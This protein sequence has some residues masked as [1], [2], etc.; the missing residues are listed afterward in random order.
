M[1]GFLSNAS[2]STSL[3]SRTGDGSGSPFALS[4][5]R[6]ALDASAPCATAGRA[7]EIAR[8]KTPIL[9]IDQSRHVKKEDVTQAE[10]ARTT[11][12]LRGGIRSERYRGKTARDGD[13]LVDTGLRLSLSLAKVFR[14]AQPAQ[15]A[16]RRPPYKLEPVTLLLVF[17]FPMKEHSKAV[18]ELLQW[19]LQLPAAPHHDHSRDGMTAL[20][21]PRRQTP[22]KGRSPVSKPE[23]MQRIWHIEPS[24]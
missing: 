2:R 1:A 3:S 5:C 22:L 12:T 6:A 23:P 14:G 24:P 7:S 18:G 9:L 4:V 16:W 11:K 17:V 8:R 19:S 13:L 15:P 10:S 21:N 20:S